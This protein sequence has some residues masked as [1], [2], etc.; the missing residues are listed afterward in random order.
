LAFLHPDLHDWAREYLASFTPGDPIGH[1]EGA[2]ALP[3]G[4]ERWIRWTD[5]ALFDE[6]GALTQFQS[7]GLDITDRKFHEARAH[8]RETRFRTLIETMVDGVI[9]ID[10]AGVIREVNPAAES[11]FGYPAEAMLGSNVSCLMPEPDRSAHDGYI[12]HYLETGEERVIGRGREVT[13]LRRDGTEFPMELAVS[14]MRTDGEVLF[15][16]I[17]RDITARKEMEDTLAVEKERLAL[18]RQLFEA[19]EQAIGVTDANGHFV[20]TNPAHERITGYSAAELAGQH[21]S[22][23][24]PTD[25]GRDYVAEV[26]RGLGT[27]GRWTAQVPLVHKD[28][29]RFVSAANLGVITDDRGETQN[30]FNL[31][32]DF[33][34]ELERQ[35]E[36]SRAKEEAERANRAKSEFLS[37]M[38]HELRTPMNAIIGFAQL[39][40]HDDH[41]DADHADNVREI[42][43]AADH[44]LDLINEVLDLA[45]VEAGRLTL[46]LE[47]VA[48]DALV[49]EVLPLVQNM[50]DNYGV[51][52]DT[53]DLAGRSV[54]ADR[55]RLKQ[56]VLNLV[57]NAVKYN[58]APGR[59]VIHAEAD[60]DGGLGIGVTDTGPGIPPE[61][62]AEMF[63]PFNRLDA[64]S[65]SSEGTG[66][67]LAFSQQVMTVM[68]GT[69]RVDS[70]V[71]QGSTFWAVLPTAE[72]PAAPTPGEGMPEAIAGPSP[73]PGTEPQTVLYLEDNPANLKL[74]S[75]L[76]RESPGVELITAENP[77]VGIELALSR[78]PNLIFLD[79]NL[80]GMDGY[81]VLEI[82]QEDET[83]RQVPVVALTANAMPKDVERGKR[84]GFADYLT[85][86]LDVAH[87]KRVVA[88][89]LGEAAASSGA[90]P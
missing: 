36:L 66:I 27:E 75:Q 43:K 11:L 81:D 34:A 17:V 79:I 14:E 71:G 12:R 22:G 26:L 46:S 44:L 25:E 90:A 59:V 78:R 52:I 51:T 16:G 7:M 28:G 58:T 56:V 4:E 30:L 37:S 86:P 40:E 5:Q 76:L 50:A 64:E 9:V 3:S 61:R 80:P 21:F 89:Y 15:T 42:L 1:F 83:L 35:E 69:L 20:Y 53:R 6:T 74:V 45:K 54:Q 77:E 23:L 10:S 84:A 88:T 87:F 19:S 24:L 73:A 2:V 70:E 82:L 60:D 13:G 39:M 47:P 57:T 8:N 31:F 85:K 55:T 49:A 48:V 72:L 68:E 65:G 38:S 63:E 32:T 67:G 41:L 33:T 18:F 29:R 62:V